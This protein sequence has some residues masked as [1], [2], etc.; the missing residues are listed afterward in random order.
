M[1]TGNRGFKMSRY[2]LSVLLLSVAPTLLAQ[3]N[4]DGYYMDDGSDVYNSEQINIDANYQRKESAADR[5]AEMRKKLE[6]ENDQMVQKKIEDIR[7]EQEQE[8]SGRLKSALKGEA[9]TGSDNDYDNSDRYDGV[10]TISAAPQRVE[11]VMEDEE[12]TNNLRNK[13]IPS[14]GVSQYD[15]ED[16]NGFESSA[17]IALSFENM[18]TNYFSLGLGLGY[19]SMSVSFIDNANFFNYYDNTYNYY[20][21][22]TDEIAYKNLNINVSAKVFFSADTTIKPF[23]GGRLGYNR[24]KLNFEERE[25]TGFNY[26]T[27]EASVTGNYAT[28]TAMIGA[29]I[30]FAANI[31]MVVDFRYTRGLTNGFSRLSRRFSPNSNAEL[32]KDKQIL[33]DIGTRLE[34]SDIA[35][36]NIGF[37]VK[38]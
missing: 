12:A 10:S 35:S 32:E 18:L 1:K 3:Q 22:T 27:T 29:E 11:A 24:T 15:G 33:S 25:Q 23:I 36:L 4:D 38:F 19:T 2:A 9:N 34:N 6:R 8:L 26:D 21:T 5:I 13:V 31:G 30:D 16:I 37:L 14:V 17:N 20:S 28:A 7:I